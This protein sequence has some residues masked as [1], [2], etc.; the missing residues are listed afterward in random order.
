MKLSVF[1]F[2]FYVVKIEVMNLNNLHQIWLLVIGIWILKML[3][4]VKTIPLLLIG[5]R[6]AEVTGTID[7]IKRYADIIS[8]LE[9]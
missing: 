9:K 8:E 6:T 1:M 5:S 7:A 3:C 2:F 4:G